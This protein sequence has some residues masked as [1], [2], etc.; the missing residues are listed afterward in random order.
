MNKIINDD[1]FKYIKIIEDNS[2]DLIITDPPYGI[3][4]KD[5]LTN[6]KKYVKKSILNDGKDDIDFK[7]FFDESYRI[8]KNNCSLFLCM[9]IDFLMRIATIINESKFKYVNTLIWRKGDMGYGNLNVMGENFEIVLH[10]SK[11][12]PKKS[13][14]LNINNKSKKRTVAEYCGNLTKHELCGHPTQKPIGLFSYIILNRTNKYELILDPFAGSG[15][16]AIACELLNR[17]Y[18]CI[19]QDADFY[20]L[21]NKRLKELNKNEYLNIINENL[22][23]KQLNGITF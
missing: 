6:N 23:I 5:N 14:I 4:F 20:N 18:I 12:S 9:R 3:S 17:N 11:N 21:I 19:E 8:L 16:T 22:Q 15:T 7:L 2:I 13:Q 1:C 10:L